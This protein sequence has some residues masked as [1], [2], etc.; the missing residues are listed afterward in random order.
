MQPAR[1]RRRTR[2]GSR[3]WST[4]ST[5]TTR[6]PPATCRSRRTS[7]SP[8]ARGRRSIGWCASASRAA[9][10]TAAQRP[11]SN[12]VF[13]IDVSGSMDEPAKLPLLVEGMRMLTR[14]LGEN[15]RV[16]IVVYAS[17]EGLALESTP[18]RQ[19]ADDPRRARPPAGRRLDR[20]R[21]G[22][23][24]GLQDRGR[25]LHQGRR[26]PRHPVHRRRLQRRRHEPRRAASG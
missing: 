17:S 11:K 2:C 23:P 10:W 14:E 15:D 3:S 24:A 22:H 13:L 26:Q 9:R 5:T 20:G 7:K 6:R 19:A 1:C 25:E 18:R 12:L 16:A 8:R 21:R 4:T